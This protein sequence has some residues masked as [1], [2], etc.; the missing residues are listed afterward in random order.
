MRD[1][2]EFLRK[3]ECAKINSETTSDDT[4]LE[5]KRLEKEYGQVWDIKELQED[6]I[7][8]SFLA[9]FCNVTRKSDNKRGMIGFQHLP[10]FYFRFVEE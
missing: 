8:H 10:R 3:L 4:D 2:T 1:N 5:R 9:P 6:F 7:I